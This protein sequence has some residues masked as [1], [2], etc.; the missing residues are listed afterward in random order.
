[1]LLSQVHK[2]LPSNNTSTTS[3]HK[4]QPMSR[5]SPSSASIPGMPQSPPPVASV[6][7][8]GDIMSLHGDSVELYK[9]PLDDFSVEVFS[10][11]SMNDAEAEP[12]IFSSPVSQAPENHFRLGNDEDAD[13]IFPMPNDSDASLTEKFFNFMF[14]A[15]LS[16]EDVGASK[17][18]ESMHLVFWRIFIVCLTLAALILCAVNIKHP[19]CFLAP[20]VYGPLIIISI[21]MAFLA[22]LRYKKAESTINLDA[23]FKAIYRYSN[24]FC[25]PD[26]D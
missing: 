18:I 15:K 8:E 25:V 12:G 3:E 2:C 6:T 5:Y 20:V 17:F 9:I 14:G 10:N 4:I 22:T 7:K 26:N 11:N 24:R 19:C 16:F 23:D 21:R 13:E 1:M